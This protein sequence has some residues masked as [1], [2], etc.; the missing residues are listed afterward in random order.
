MADREVKQ[1]L[2]P[3]RHPLALTRHAIL[4]KFLKNN[5]QCRN[6]IK[7]ATAIYFWQLEYN[8]G[9]Q[10]CQ[11]TT[12]FMESSWNKTLTNDDR[13][14]ELGLDGGLLQKMNSVVCSGTCE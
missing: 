1:L 2:V 10:I 9:I 11:E 3:R 5:S 13:N 14:S 12:V 7:F 6:L 8:R 4:K